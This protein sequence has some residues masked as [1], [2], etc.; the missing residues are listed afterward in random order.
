MQ[1]QN[2]YKAHVHI[3]QQTTNVMYPLEETEFSKQIANMQK[4][5]KHSLRFPSI[6]CFPFSSIFKPHPLGFG[7]PVFI[8]T[9]KPSFLWNGRTYVGVNIIGLL[10]IAVADVLTETKSCFELK[11]CFHCNGPF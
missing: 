7:P 1:P 6:V 9:K 5:D 2:L 8:I 11:M 10:T 4:V 3:S